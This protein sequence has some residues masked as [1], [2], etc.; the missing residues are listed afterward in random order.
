MSGYPLNPQ[1]RLLP[2]GVVPTDVVHIPGVKVAGDMAVWNG[3]AWVKSPSSHLTTTSLA[4]SAITGTPSTLA[5]YAISDA[6]GLDAELSAIAGLSSAADR[7]PY[8]TGSGTAALATFTAAGRALVDDADATAQRTTLGLGT[9]ATQS[10]TFSGTSSGTNTGDQT[11]VAGNAGTATALQTARKINGVN[12]DGTAAIAAMHASYH[13]YQSRMPIFS[14]MIL[15]SGTAYWVYVGVAPDATPI[16]FME[17]FMAVVGLGTQVAEVAIASTP[18]G[19]DKTGKTYTVVA[20]TGTV[21]SLLATLS[22]KHNS[23]TFAFTPTAGTH[24]WVG[25]RTA[26]ATTQPTFSALTGDMGTGDLQTTPASGVLTLNST[27]TGTIVTAARAVA[28]CPDMR[29]TCD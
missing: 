1:T 7:L 27:Y 19:P 8:F 20:V 4:F 11:T 3:S 2:P 12:F 10:G 25:I 24:Y 15:T 28:Q 26:M 23:S 6:Q 16:K 14:T 22:T 29:L 17:I 18:A 9:L 13:F 21:D 5:G